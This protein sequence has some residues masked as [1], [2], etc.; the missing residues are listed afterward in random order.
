MEPA[1]V[2]VERGLGQERVVLLAAMT[3]GLLTLGLAAF[4]LFGLLSYVVA[5]RAPEIGVR[6]ALG[7]AP[8]QV[9]RAV[10]RDASRL[11]VYGLLIGLP[12]SA[13]AGRL[14]SGLFYGVSPYDPVAFAAAVALLIAVAGAASW[15]PAR[16]ASRVHPM[17]ALRQE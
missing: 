10:V 6:L 17:V 14:A 13:L 11:V 15:G 16:R 9:G 5:R 3:F 4:G 8:S 12:L 1:V 7:A 2:Y